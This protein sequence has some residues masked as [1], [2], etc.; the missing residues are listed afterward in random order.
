V[1]SLDDDLPATIRIAGHWMHHLTGATLSL[2]EKHDL[3]CSISDFG[4]PKCG[5]CFSGDMLDFGFRKRS[6]IPDALTTEP[7]V[8]GLRRAME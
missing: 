3:A 5:F 6:G 4:L 8:N 1:V 7:I 2:A